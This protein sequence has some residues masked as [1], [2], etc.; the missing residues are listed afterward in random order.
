M[1]GSI[2]PYWIGAGVMVGI[3]L[4][5]ALWALISVTSGIDVEAPTWPEDEDGAHYVTRR[6]R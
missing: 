3:V 5:M 6:P 1:I 2:W 4:A